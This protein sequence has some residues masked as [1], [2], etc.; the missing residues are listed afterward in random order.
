[1]FNRNDPFYLG[2]LT[3]RRSTLSGNVAT[4]SG[5]AIGTAGDFAIVS[6]STLSG[7]TAHDGGAIY[8]TT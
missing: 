3:V 7:N 5:G 2:R 6:Q 1:M 8:G 4:D